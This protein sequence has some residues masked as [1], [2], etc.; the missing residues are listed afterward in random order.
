MNLYPPRI[1][2]AGTGSGVGKTTVTLG[3]LS[4]L[5]RR[6][7]RVQ[8]F[9]AGPDYLDPGFHRLATGRPSRNLDTWMLG[10]DG[11]REV[12]LKG[13]QGADLCLIEGVMGLFDGNDSRSNEGSTAEIAAELGAP[14]VLILDAG[15]AARSVAAVV[16]GFQVFDPEV[17]IGGVILNRV[18]SEGHHRMLKSAIEGECGIPVLG[19]F[20]QDPSH[21]L[22]EGN[23]G[24]VPAVDPQGF[25]AWL[26][27]L[28]DKV[29]EN[30]DLKALLALARVTESSVKP[31]DS[32][33]FIHSPPPPPRPVIAVAR[34]EAFCFYYPENLELLQS[35]GARLRF[36]SPLAGEK[37]P[38][39]A[40][41][42]YIGGGFPEEFAEVLTKQEEVKRSI[43]DRI[44]AGLPTYAEGG[45]FMY[46]CE[47]L[48]DGEGRLHPMAGVIPARVEMGPGLSAFGYR[49]VRAET[50]T[51]LLR[52]G[53]TARGHEFHYSR[54]TESPE[55]QPAWRTEGLYGAGWE[56]FSAGR[57]LATYIHLHFLSHPG[58]ARRW[59]DTCRQYRREKA[60]L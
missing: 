44:E 42:L 16:R 8:A 56:G 9:K 3:L 4:A 25:P 27:A 19:A 15:T 33:R 24:L 11:M 36:F 32:T 23:L 18:G 58:M 13:A 28:A 40:E 38:D 60:S 41:G 50:D 31:P 17:R 51:L 2:I 35:E 43:R 55:W 52:K 30:V 26:E 49:E 21:Q 34:D 1:V 10:T 48:K 39:E 37:L 7:I 22:P 6:G 12:F 14:V 45:G 5:T 54:L 47:S 29:D 20:H 59:V 57:L 46:L 53:K